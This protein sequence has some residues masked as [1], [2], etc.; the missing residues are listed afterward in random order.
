VSLVARHLEENGIPTV[1][2]ATARDIVE[3]CGVARLLHVDFPLG[4]PMGE[5]WN[6]AQQKETLERAFTLLETATTPN[7][8]V[9]AP[10]TWSKGD[11]WKELV[12]TEERPF[13]AGEAKEEWLKRKEV[14]RQA[15]KDGI[16]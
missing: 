8:T 15:K 10:Y 13:L 3:T 4:S 2:V 14:Y 11:S 12:F 9:T 7:T 6:A 1:V 5:P 16:V